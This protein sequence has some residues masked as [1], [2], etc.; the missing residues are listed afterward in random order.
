MI[1][2]LIPSC[3]VINSFVC[4]ELGSVLFSTRWNDHNSFGHVGAPLMGMA[5]RV[6][7]SVMYSIAQIITRSPV[8]DNRFDTSE[9]CLYRR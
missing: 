8:A 6:S 3:S 9:G 7:F 1:S 4:Q 2:F 5:V